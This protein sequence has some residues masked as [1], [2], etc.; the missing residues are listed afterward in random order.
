MGGTVRVRTNL[1]GRE[2]AEIEYDATES[3]KP[4]PVVVDADT[5]IERPDL[6]RN[7]VTRVK[8]GHAIPVA[9]LNFPRRLAYPPRKRRARKA[10]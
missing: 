5:L 9:L 1:G 6:G 10:R 2:V 7:A 4:K 3:P 8:A